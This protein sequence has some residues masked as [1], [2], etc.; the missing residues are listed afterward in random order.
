MKQNSK[1]FAGLAFGI[2]LSI[3]FNVQPLQSAKDSIEGDTDPV[4]GE[5]ISQETANK[6]IN[7]YDGATKGGFIGKKY[8]RDVVGLMGDG[9]I[10]YRYYTQINEGGKTSTGIIFYPSKE[11]NEVLRTGTNSF[12]PLL[13]ESPLN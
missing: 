12:C 13:C 7:E 4:K 9:Y 1:F 6:L 8:L 5:W 3:I 10:K 11:S 2:L